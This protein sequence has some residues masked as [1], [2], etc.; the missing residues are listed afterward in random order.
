MILIKLFYHIKIKFMIMIK[1]YFDK[2]IY[3]NIYYKI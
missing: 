3:K 2:I 1:L